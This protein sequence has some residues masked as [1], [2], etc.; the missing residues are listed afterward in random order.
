MFSIFST[1]SIATEEALLLIDLDSSVIFLQTF[2]HLSSRFAVLIL[3]RCDKDLHLHSD[4]FGNVL[5]LSLD[6]LCF[7]VPLLYSSLVG[8]YDDLV[9]L[10]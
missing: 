6:V 4:I 10:I 7:G 1:G 3:M 2:P 5:D 9:S 8:E